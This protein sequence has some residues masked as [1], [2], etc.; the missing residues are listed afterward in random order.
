[1]KFVIKN[2]FARW[3]SF[4]I[5]HSQEDIY[6]GTFLKGK[7]PLCAGKNTQYHCDRGGLLFT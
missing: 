4:E 1:M 7:H 2:N 6:Q 5:T 3:L